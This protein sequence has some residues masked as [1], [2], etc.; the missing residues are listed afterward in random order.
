MVAWYAS[1]PEDAHTSLDGMK[2]GIA[3]AKKKIH[4]RKCLKPALACMKVDFAL[5]MPAGVAWFLNW[6]DDTDRATARGELLAEV[7]RTL[8]A[9]ERS[10]RPAA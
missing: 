10:P 2:V 1:H 6:W 5:G 7:K 3:R 8:A 4:L 9:R